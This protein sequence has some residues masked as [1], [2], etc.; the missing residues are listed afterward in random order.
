[1]PTHKKFFMYAVSVILFFIFSQF[2]IFFA[3]H[4]TYSYK[5]IEVNSTLVSEATVKTNSNSGVA[6]IKIL[7]NTDSE[8]ENKYIKIDCYSKHDVL[9]GTEYIEIEKI[10]TNEEKEFE[11]KFNYNNVDH[12]VINVIENVD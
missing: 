12:A 7:N 2:V 3:L 10:P 6:K 1:M 9:M 11:V 5:K 4:S 8:L